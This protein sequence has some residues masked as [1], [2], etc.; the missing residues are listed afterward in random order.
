MTKR[1]LCLTLLLT[2]GILSYNFAQD[3]TKVGLPEGAIARLGKGGINLIRFS[4]DGTH[5]VVGTDVG[6]WVYDVPDGNETALF[7]GHTGQVNALAFSSDGKTF[8]SGGFVNPV[9]QVWDVETKSKLST[10]PLTREP[11]SLPALTF[12][13]EILISTN[14][15]REVTY[16]HA[17]TGQKLSESHLDTSINTVTF[18]QDGSTLAIGDRNGRIQLWDTTT[19]SQQADLDGH[20]GGRDSEILA[21][22]FSPDG[23][24][25]A[26]GSEDKTVRLWDTQNHTKLGTLSGHTGWVT[27]VAFSEDGNTFASG[28]ANKTIKLWDLD[29]QQERA[30]ITGHKNTINA[31]AFA[32]VGTPLYGMCLASGSTDGTIRFWNPLNG[33]ELVT[34]TSGHIESVK[35]V[36][37]SKDGTTVTTAAFNGI[38]DVWSLQTG[39]ELI[40]LTNGQCDAADA[41]A[42][43]PDAT[44]FVRTAREGLIAFNPDGFGGRMNS[45]GGTRLQL[46]KIATEAEIPGPWQDIGNNASQSIFSPVH[47]ILAV[48]SHKEI[49]AWH[50]NTETELFRFDAQW[51]P[52]TDAAFSPDGKWLA[53]IDRP[54]K[55]QVWNVE[56]PHE[57]AIISTQKAAAMAFSPDSATL[58]I[59]SQGTIYLW[60]FRTEPAD[61]PI[62]IPGGLRGFKTVLTFSPDGTI[63]VGSGMQGWSNPI[64]LWDVERG[65]TLGILSGHTEPVETLVFSHD[66][67]T[68]ASGSQDGTVLLWDWKKII[69]KK[70]QGTINDE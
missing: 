70:G 52:R 4:P 59:A 21:L 6:A 62:A 2:V 1:L 53:T 64:A 11:Y 60:K 36:A 66:R 56:A 24:I 40:T 26:S 37:F 5:L 20:G 45:S 33:E 3:N 63:L 61:E 25:L 10:V 65:R 55:A 27:A 68:L 48:S 42:L 58:A 41:I 15:H 14:G 28:D 30:T 46:W 8:A 16:W 47:G 9:I 12:Y 32:P 31:L 67:K 54:G 13:G 49:Q 7:T 19:S 17:D 23:K 35:A 29:T 18:S 44:Y 57:P 69:D 51:S 34:F 22:A 39:R 50:I 43:S 38:V